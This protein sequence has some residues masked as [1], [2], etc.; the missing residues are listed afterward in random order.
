MRSLL[1]L[2][3]FSLS[4]NADHISWLG[5]YDTALEKAKKEQKPMMVLLV[6]KDCKPCNEIIVKNFINRDYIEALNEKYVA[7]MVTYEGRT[8]YPIEL[9]YSTVFPTLF[10]VSSRDEHFLEEPLYGEEIDKYEEF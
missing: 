3:I 4:L 2:L 9:F 7:V 5:N 8:S 10:F 1:F 6:K